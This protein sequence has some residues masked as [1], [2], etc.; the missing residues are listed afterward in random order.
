[1]DREAWE[2]TVQEVKRIKEFF[3]ESNMTENTHM[4]KMLW[5][6]LNELFGQHNNNGGD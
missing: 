4:H 3:E 6:N 1:M 5:K 2:A